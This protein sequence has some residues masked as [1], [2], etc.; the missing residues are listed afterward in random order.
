MSEGPCSAGHFA[1]APKASPARG[2][3]EIGPMRILGL[4]LCLVAGC[5]GADRDVSVEAAPSA[6]P[7]TELRIDEWHTSTIGS[8]GIHI[9]AR[10]LIPSGDPECH[11]GCMEETVIRL[12]ADAYHIELAPGEYTL[13]LRPGNPD[14]DLACDWRMEAAGRMPLPGD[15][16]SMDWFTPRSFETIPGPIRSRWGCNAARGKRSSFRQQFA[17]SEAGEY[18]L[19]VVEQWHSAR[20]PQNPGCGAYEIQIAR[21]THRCGE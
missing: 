6:G 14:A 16:E 21:G 3:K 20:D 2:S 1:D 9:A 11:V 10:R 13:M 19:L 17:V 8:G 12:P 18:W 4:T 7:L 5:G 15:L